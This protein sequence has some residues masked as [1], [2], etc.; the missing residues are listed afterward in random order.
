MKKIK[1][2]IK[3]DPFSI[4]LI[5]SVLAVFLLTFSNISQT[6]DLAGLIYPTTT[7]DEID[8]EKPNRLQVLV[9]EHD[10]QINKGYEMNEGSRSIQI[11]DPEDIRG[12]ISSGEV[13][14]FDEEMKDII[15]EAPSG[16]FVGWSGCDAD[17]EN[18]CQVS[19]T[20]HQKRK[21]E[22][23][24]SNPEPRTDQLQ[25]FSVSNNPI[26][27]SLSEDWVNANPELAYKAAYID[28]EGEIPSTVGNLNP[29]LQLTLGGNKLGGVIPPEIGNLTATDY[30]GLQK[31][32]LGGLIPPEI[33]NLS[34]IYFLAYMNELEGEIPPS[35]GNM[36]PR[37]QRLELHDN[38]LKGEVPVGLLG[39]GTLTP[40]E[41]RLYNNRLTR[42][43]PGFMTSAPWF[44]VNFNGNLFNTSAAME[45]LEDASNNPGTYI[46]FCNNPA[47]G[48]AVTYNLEGEMVDVNLHDPLNEALDAGWDVY[49]PLALLQEFKVWSQYRP[50]GPPPCDGSPSCETRTRTKTDEDGNEY[51]EEYCANTSTCGPQTQTDYDTPP[52]GDVPCAR[53]EG[54]D[55]IETPEEMKDNNEGVPDHLEHVYYYDS[56]EWWATPGDDC[57]PV[58]ELDPGSCGSPS[59]CPHRGGYSCEWEGEEEYDYSSPTGPYD[60]SDSISSGCMDVRKTY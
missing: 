5:A 9:F 37:V 19:V 30:I 20:D 45:A 47:S 41:L 2:I 28:L 23:H 35:I 6:Y 56:C 40:N 3:Q 33:G 55:R 12:S 4:L 32:E 34:P 53:L 54:G 59:G 16:N 7:T 38:R 25:L 18:R 24:Y 15:L 8:G 29:N 52:I 44:G 10:H 48:G 58:C 42:T 60:S 27:G 49:I 26:G 39:V 21:V 46:D 51:E 17:T 22:A 43:E 13:I 36:G 31:N 11:T 50:G 57:K 14:D 1:N